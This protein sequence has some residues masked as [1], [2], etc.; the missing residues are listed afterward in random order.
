MGQTHPRPMPAGEVPLCIQLKLR[1]TTSYGK[2]RNH[3]G[4]G[5][6]RWKMQM[7]RRPKC[8]HS[9]MTLTWGTQL[10]KDK[11]LSY[12]FFKKKSLFKTKNIWVLLSPN[13]RLEK[14]QSNGPNRIDAFAQFFRTVC[15]LQKED[16]PCKFRQVVTQT[17]KT[18]LKKG[19]G[20]FWN[21]IWWYV[22][23]LAWPAK[24]KSSAESFFQTELDLDS[25]LL[26][27][28]Y[29]NYYTFQHP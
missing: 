19:K 2:E 7:G 3:S 26:P 20:H 17:P 12:F 10:D 1:V 22:T 15:P 29:L 4:K 9:A 27:F 18:G 5:F 6:L 8:S 13:K 23:V 11:K 14:L 16:T 21:T 25:S 24:N 28:T